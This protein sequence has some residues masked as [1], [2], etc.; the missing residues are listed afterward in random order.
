M[1]STRLILS[2]AILLVATIALTGQGL[3]SNLESPV[4]ASSA[5]L[6]EHE[7]EE[8]IAMPAQDQVMRLLERTINHY[9][10]ASEEIEKRANGWIGKI[11][12]TPELSKLS[13]VAY[14][15]SDLRVRA[16]ALEIWRIKAGFRKSSETVDQIIN[17]AAAD[18]ERKYFFL[19]Q[20]GILGNRGATAQ[21]IRHADALCA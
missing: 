3:I 13:E 15:S 12:S 4:A 14:F 17:A 21:G 18:A 10:G 8:L 7:L 16:A 11:Q 5:V 9:S 1:R 20:L 6:S 2:V 19:S